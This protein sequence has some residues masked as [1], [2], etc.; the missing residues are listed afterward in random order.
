MQTET[1]L[2]YVRLSYEFSFYVHLQHCTSEG[3]L[4]TADEW[5]NTIPYGGGYQ[6]RILL[7]GVSSLAVAFRL[8]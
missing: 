5:K 4:R 2:V 6:V 1:E 7:S 8:I 3:M